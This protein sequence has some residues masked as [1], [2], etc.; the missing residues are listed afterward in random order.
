MATW[1]SKSFRPGGGWGDDKI[2][3]TVRVGWGFTMQVPRARDRAGLVL[4]S[5]VRARDKDTIGV[6]AEVRVRE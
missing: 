2:Q 3:D 6:G 1:H 5:R 4:A